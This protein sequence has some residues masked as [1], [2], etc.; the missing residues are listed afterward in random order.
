MGGVA[1]IAVAVVMVIT[2]IYFIKKSSKQ[3]TGILA[4]TWMDSQLDTDP[5]ALGKDSSIPRF[6][7]SIL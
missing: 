2:A 4:T 3:P 7:G 6:S 1:V 5:F